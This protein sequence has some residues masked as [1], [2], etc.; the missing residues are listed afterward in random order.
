MSMS[1]ENAKRK[2]TD[3][4]KWIAA[5]YLFSHISSSDGTTA[6]MDWVTSDEK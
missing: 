5:A 1:A 6:F 4:F 2:S 3:R